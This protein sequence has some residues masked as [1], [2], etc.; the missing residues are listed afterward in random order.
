[1]NTRKRQANPGAMGERSARHPLRSDGVPT[2]ANE[3]GNALADELTLSEMVLI[4]SSNIFHA[5]RPAVRVA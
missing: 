3:S 4:R 2:F 1:V 5:A